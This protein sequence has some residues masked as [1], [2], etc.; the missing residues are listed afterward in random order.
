MDAHLE[1]VRVKVRKE[2]QCFGC[3]RMLMAG[4]SFQKTTGVMDGRFYHTYLCRV[5]EEV[6][7]ECDSGHGEEFYEGEI[8]NGWPEEWEETRAALENTP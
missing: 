6:Y 3:M 4:T 2:R 1:T 5:C 8:K 7:F